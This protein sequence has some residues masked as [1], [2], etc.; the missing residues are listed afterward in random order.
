MVLPAGSKKPGARPDRRGGVDYTN[1]ERPA[2]EGANKNV[3]PQASGPAP[4]PHRQGGASG[5][6]GRAAGRLKSFMRW[7]SMEGHIDR[8]GRK[9]CTLVTG[10]KPV[11]RRRRTRQPSWYPYA[12]HVCNVVTINPL[13]DIRA[14]SYRREGQRV[15]MHCTFH[16]LIE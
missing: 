3:P 14:G 7:F 5:N 13:P 16:T 15:S 12:A 9:S 4:K 1:L 2:R 11:A 6:V 8:D 10:R